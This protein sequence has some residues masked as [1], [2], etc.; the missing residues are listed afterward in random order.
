MKILAL[1]KISGKF[2]VTIPQ[3]VREVLKLSE[4]DKILWVLEGEKVYIQKT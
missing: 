1:T 3:D 2:L 4:G